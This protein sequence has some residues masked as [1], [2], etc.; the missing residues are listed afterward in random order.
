V[1][2]LSWLEGLDT[3][4]QYARMPSELGIRASIVG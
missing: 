4:A 2:K 3:L 1:S